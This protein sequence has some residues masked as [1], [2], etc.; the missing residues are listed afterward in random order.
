MADT[1]KSFKLNVVA[2]APEVAVSKAGHS[3][4]DFLQLVGSTSLIGLAAACRAP[5]DTVVPYINRPDDLVP[6]NPVHYATA[7][8]LNG[9]GEGL[10]VTAYEG[11]PTK[12]EGN[13]KH[14]GSNGGTGIFEQASIL[15]LYDPTRAKVIK[16]KGVGASKDKLLR[17][18]KAKAEAS[19][20]DGGAKVRFLLEPSSSQLLASQLEQLK[21]QLPNATVRFYSPTASSAASDGAKVAFG[22]D[23]ALVPQ[24]ELEKA[25]VIVSLDDDFLA[26]QPGTLKLAKQ[27][28]ERREP[29]GKLNRLYVAECRISVTGSI[30]D[31]RFAM[32]SA[33]VG[34]FA[35]DLFNL[36]NGGAASSAFA[37]QA[38][39]VAKDLQAHKG[40]S[41]VMAGERQ[42]AAVHAL[43]AAINS[44]LGNVGEGKPVAYTT[45]TRIDAN[46]GP[47]SLKALIEEINANKVETLVLNVFDPSFARYT[48]LPLA[49][50]LKKV[51]T[52]VYLA[53]HEDRTAEGVEW[54]VPMSHYLE[55]WGDVRT[56]DGV[57]SLQQPLISPLYSSLSIEELISGFV[58]DAPRSSHDLLKGMVSKLDPG[59]DHWARTLQAGFVT[60]TEKKP[61]EVALN[62]GAVTTAAAALQA[63]GSGLEVN[64]V[65]DY[66]LF[67]G[68]F[69]AN[70]W[71]YETPDPIS[72]LC[73]D[74][75]IYLSA[76]TAKDLKLGI[77]QVVE[78]TVKGKTVKGAVLVVPGHADDAVTLPLG[79][80]QKMGP[81]LG[82]EDEDAIGFDAYALRTSDAA[83]FAAGELKPTSDRYP[84]AITQGHFSQEGRKLAMV[85][86][87]SEKKEKVEEELNQVRGKLPTLYGEFEYSGYKWAMGVDLGKC[88]GCSACVIACVAENNI[89]VVG[90]SNVRKGREMHW[91]RIDRYIEFDNK[92]DEEAGRNPLILNQAS[93][94]QHCENA[95]CEYVCP[96]N[97]TMHNEEGLNEMIYNRCIGTRYCSNNC[98]YK[99]RRFNFF[100]YTNDRTETEKMAMNP[101]VTVRSRGVM[102]K[103]TYCVQ[104]IERGRITSEIAGRTMKGDEVQSACSQACPTGAIHFGSLHDATAAVSKDHKDERR[105]DLLHSL[106]TRPRTAY[107]ARITNRN[108]DLEKA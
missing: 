72:K 76:K 54:F 92:A 4:R 17:A 68:R 37:K 69:G 42:P 9:V 18:L 45:S 89:P 64:F 57:A 36:V 65:T 28:G 67:D 75:A 77:E 53:T 51:P 97:A 6:G 2:E 95:P 49:D 24:Y 86:D 62:V 100:A 80:G 29:E 23:K 60:G 10:L 78:I 50:A 8:S 96:A 90:K 101:D 11:R 91:L 33:D 87:V 105:F 104:R 30:A 20:A 1:L 41:V 58:D 83:W 107:L 106:G 82:R 66:K 14:P 94:C 61:E 19:K 3:R 98:P 46:V 85:F 71:L 39:A 81:A 73:W 74:N 26:A 108:P 93:M 63:A 21:A 84:L 43:A 44:L 34:L 12:V 22:G 52:V 79:Y 103:C 7:W 70:P 31:H 88:T 40:S 27:F 5:H 13:A 35:R 55:T 25:D 32:K 16:N 48:D 38:Q 99:Q 102:E 15:G 47:A 56:A 59:A